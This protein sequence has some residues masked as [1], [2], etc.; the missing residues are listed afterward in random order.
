MPNQW[1]WDVGFMVV[2][3]VCSN[4]IEWALHVLAHQRINL[5]VLRDIHKIHMEHH[6][7]HYPIKHLLLPGPYKSGGGALAFGPIVATILVCAFALL[8][9]R[10][11]FI[12]SIESMSFLGVS[13]Y[14]HDQFHIQGSWLERYDWFLKRR[15]RHFWHH[16]HLLENM[17]LGGIDPSCDKLFGTFQEVAVPNANMNTV[18]R[19]AKRVSM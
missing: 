18:P 4:S 7:L 8:K 10:Y 19:A 1:V 15:Y 17:S 5:P 2:T 14:L 9:L 11:F 13:V 12:F 3:W 16:G 6:R